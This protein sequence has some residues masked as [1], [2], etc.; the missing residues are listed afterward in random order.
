[1]STWEIILLGIVQ[2]ISEFLPISSDGHLVIVEA[3]LGHNTENLSLN[4]ALHF[5]TLMS[6]LLVYRKDILPALKQPKLVAAIVVATLPVVVAALLFGDLFESASNSPLIAGIGLLY[7]AGL[8]FLTPGIDNGTRDMQDIRLRDALVIGLLQ[9]LAPL[10]GVS[11]SGSTIVAALLMGIRRDVAAN[12]SFYIAVPAIA[13]AVTKELLFD[14]LPRTIASGPLAAGMLVAFVVG[15][16][17]LQGLLRIVSAR[18]LIWFAWY[19]LVLAVLTIL[20]SMTGWLSEASP[21]PDNVP[22]AAV[23]PELNEAPLPEDMS[24]HQNGAAP[25]LSVQDR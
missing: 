11:R 2:G 1:M 12:F 25:A 18:K 5:G 13:G 6:I 7:T 15:V 3:L 16:I 14:D 19:V 23:A 4:I 21:A 22:P 9:A 17:A 8:L 20:G 10:P 24:L